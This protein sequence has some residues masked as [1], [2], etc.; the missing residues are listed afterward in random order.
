MIAPGQHFLIAERLGAGQ[1]GGVDDIAPEA[2]N[3]PMGQGV[4]EQFFGV[5]RHVAVGEIGDPRLPGN[6]RKTLHQ[7][8]VMVFAAAQL[9]FQVDAAGDFRTEAAVDPNHDRQH[10]HQ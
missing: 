9:L 2:W 6:G 8:A 7:P 10:R 1:V 3:Q 4:A 5:G